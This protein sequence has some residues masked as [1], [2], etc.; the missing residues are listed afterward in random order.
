MNMVVKCSECECTPTICHREE[1]SRSTTHCGNCTGEEQCCCMVIHLI[2]DKDECCTDSSCTRLE[3]RFSGLNPQ[4]K[5]T[6]GIQFPQPEIGF[7]IRSF[8]FYAKGLYAA[9]LGIEILCISAVEIGENTGL[10]LS[11]SMLVELP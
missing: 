7:G 1:S 2:E 6:N 11:V 3:A 9:A 10:Y 4:V 8:L 5:P